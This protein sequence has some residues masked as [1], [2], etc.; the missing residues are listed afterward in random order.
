MGTGWD[1]R[2]F[3]GRILKKLIVD[4]KKSYYKLQDPS[5]KSALSKSIAYL[6]QTQS[7]LIRDERNIEKRIERLEQLA[8]LAQ[9]GVI[10]Q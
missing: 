7:A 9:K 10:T 8:G 3:Y 1:S 2:G 5:K 4:Q 6:I